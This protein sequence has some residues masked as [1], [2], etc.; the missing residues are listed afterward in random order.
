MFQGLRRAVQRLVRVPE[1]NGL[2]IL[3]IQNVAHTG[4]RRQTV[5]QVRSRSYW[6]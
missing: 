2:S 1:F 3:S 5:S 6:P 4:G